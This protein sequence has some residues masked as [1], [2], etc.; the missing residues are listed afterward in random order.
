MSE[1]FISED[2]IKPILIKALEIQE[3]QNGAQPDSLLH[4]TLDKVSVKELQTMAAELG[5]APGVL[6]QALLMYRYGD[7]SGAKGGLSRR[8]IGKPL[9]MDD[10]IIVPRTLSTAEL[11]QLSRLLSMVIPQGGTGQVSP[12]GLLW[13]SSPQL[14]GGSSGTLAD[15]LKVDVTLGDQ[16]TL[17]RFTQ[18]MRQ[19]AGALFG[20]IMGGFGGG[21]GFGVGFGVGIG[22]LGSAL[23]AGLFPPAAILI[24]YGLARVSYGAMFKHTGVK[25]AQVKKEILKTFRTTQADG[26][27]EDSDSQVQNSD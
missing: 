18:D 11:D 9:R 13:Q 16:S 21:V 4:G 8:F 19:S 24:A 6:E 7:T 14:L 3:N 22:A 23:F 1:K 17:I 5:I 26:A 12:T 2:D 10:Y 20:G 27:L 15:V 25:I